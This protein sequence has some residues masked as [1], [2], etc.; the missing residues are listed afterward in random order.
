MKAVPTAVMSQDDR[1]EKIVISVALIEFSTQYE[2]SDPELAEYAKHLADKQ[3][4]PYD[5]G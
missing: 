1:L 4:N 5:S 3:L 2:Q